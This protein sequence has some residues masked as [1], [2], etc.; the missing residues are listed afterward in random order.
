MGLLIAGTFKGL[1][2][3]SSAPA[4]WARKS[5]NL[6]L[7]L[8]DFQAIQTPTPFTTEPQLGLAH[9]LSAVS[10]VRITVAL[11][12]TSGFIFGL[13]PYLAAKEPDRN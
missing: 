4:I 10:H 8:E 2:N 12:G 11:L 6:T 3:V 13:G 7:L 1:V 9:L 5:H